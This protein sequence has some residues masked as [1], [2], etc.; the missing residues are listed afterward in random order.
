[1]SDMA[2]GTNEGAS[3]NDHRTLV[4][5]SAEHAIS[6][7]GALWCK[8]E[9]SHAS[10][11]LRVYKTLTHHSA[12]QVVCVIFSPASLVDQIGVCGLVAD[13]PPTVVDLVLRCKCEISPCLT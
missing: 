11:I 3:S 7:R 10:H 13:R 8:Y 2:P 6:A 1:M 5:P 4:G 9:V 12:V